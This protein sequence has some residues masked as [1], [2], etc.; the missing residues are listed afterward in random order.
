MRGPRPGVEL[1]PYDSARPDARICLN[2]NESPYPPP[3]SFYTQLEE[4]LARLEANRYPD[5]TCSSLRE[6]LSDRCGSHVLV[7]AGSNQVIFALLLTYA[8]T[9]R[10]VGIFEPTYTLYASFARLIGSEI[11]SVRRNSHF[12]VTDVD[13]MIA[14]SPDAILLCSPNNPTGLLDPPG[15]VEELAS[16][17]PDALI[18]VDEAYREFALPEERQCRGTTLPSNAVSVRTFSKAWAM[19]S[20]RVGYAIGAEEVLDPASGALFPYSVSALSQEAAL[21]ALEHEND[22]YERVSRIVAERDRLL[23]AMTSIPEITVYPSDANFILFRPP[24]ARTLWSDLVEE[25]ILIRDCSSWPG[26]EGCLR[27]TVGTPE[28]NSEFMSAL[29]GAITERRSG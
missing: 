5:R 12:V 21:I 28:E 1:A 10:K 3:A 9:G 29:S 17:L 2:S 20:F 27:V 6:V 26:L 18:I 24:D 16:S 13:E 8:G 23:S 7:G 19:A 22:M 25:G 15:L 11:I 14:A 4:R